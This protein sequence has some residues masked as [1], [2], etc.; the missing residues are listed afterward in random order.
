MSIKSNYINLAWQTGGVAWDLNSIN[1]GS[2][3][4]ADAFYQIQAAE[5]IASFTCSQTASPSTFD[6]F[7]ERDD[8]AVV[9]INYT[10][11][12]DPYFETSN[13]HFRITFYSDENRESVVF[14][15]FSLLDM[16]RWFVG[17]HETSSSIMTID[18]VEVEINE[19]V[20]VFYSPEI[21]PIEKIENQEIYE[22]STDVTEK[23]L[24]CG[25][26]YYVDVDIYYLSTGMFET[27]QQFEYRAPC[28]IT[29]DAQ[30]RENL[31][32][33]NWIS[34]AQGR[35][36]FLISQSSNN[37]IYPQVSANA[38][39]QFVI[40]W[41]DHR[42]SDP[43][44]GVLSYKPQIY[45]GIYDKI[46]D[47]FWSGGQGYIDKMMIDVGFKPQVL[48]DNIDNFHVLGHLDTSV[49]NYKCPV[50]IGVEQDLTCPCLL[51]DSDFFGLDQTNRDAKEYLIAR[52][53]EEDAYGSF[54]ISSENIISIVKDCLVRIDVQGITGA[55][56]IRMRNE[57]DSNWSKWT[58]IDSEFGLVN[59][60]DD[61][62]PPSAFR[63]DNER[64]IVPWVL[65]PGSGL[66]NVC[67]QVLTFFGISPTFCV[68]IMANYE[69][70]GYEVELYYDEGFTERVPTHEGLPVVG[71]PPIDGEISAERD[72]YVKVIVKDIEKLRTIKKIKEIDWGIDDG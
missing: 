59:R 31:D 70:V 56:A 54:V 35:Q 25:I 21:L 12:L 63:I 43:S 24:I 49:R 65:S 39:G 41:Q 34:S 30:W 11:G 16:K 6:Y 2:L 23:S 69:D 9:Q 71:N 72:V 1:Q 45:Y 22:I 36:D 5:A 55:Y 20:S 52:V 57:T 7:C 8:D 42:S 15:A 28:N 46:D 50:E 38:S 3:A 67:I 26:K 37:A 13:A 62:S 19:E 17:K 53:Y 18:G 40:A 29:K 60:S 47:Q 33:S 14:S 27:I 61:I 66:K 4:F 58:N 64:F 48:S 51:T 44:W 10:K 32:A 68:D